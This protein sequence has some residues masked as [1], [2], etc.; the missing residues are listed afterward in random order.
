MS[1]NPVSSAILICLC[2]YSLSC[3]STGYSGKQEKLGQYF[4][5][6][7]T[8]PMNCGK[9]VFSNDND[10]FCIDLACER[11]EIWGRAEERWELKYSTS[12][13]E[14]Y[15]DCLKQL[16]KFSCNGTRV[17]IG[18][19]KHTLE[20]VECDEHK[21]WSKIGTIE[22]SDAMENDAYFSP[23][24]TSV[25]IISNSQIIL[26]SQGAFRVT[27][28][29]SVNNIW[30]KQG[31]IKHDKEVNRARFS[32]NGM[33][34][35]TASDDG[36]CKIWARVEGKWQ[37]TTIIIQHSQI[38]NSA[39]FSNDDNY[40]ITAS[41]DGCCKIFMRQDSQ[42]SNVAWIQNNIIAPGKA[43][44]SLNDDLAH[45]YQLALNNGS[46]IA[47][48]KARFNHDGTRIFTMSD[49]SCIR[50]WMCGDNNEWMRIAN[51]QSIVE[52]NNG[53]YISRSEK[54][55]VTYAGNDKVALIWEEN[56]EA[57]WVQKHS[58]ECNSKIKKIVFI[59]DG[60]HLMIMAEQTVI[61]STKE[62]K[63]WVN[64][65]IVKVD[66]NMTIIGSDCSPDGE[67]VVIITFNKLEL[68]KEED[69]TFTGVLTTSIFK[70]VSNGK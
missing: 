61:L 47:T 4:I 18:A 29:E 14:R 58:V 28:W 60:N 70:I 51:F 41:N 2:L 10:H 24:G 7:I 53:V 20:I 49:D 45:D 34:I 31:T 67:N 19:T 3:F 63:K 48:T 22:H 37:D 50:V 64:N 35:V 16:S 39:W 26:N 12:N 15:H 27:I 40:I 46:G 32:G 36:T 68:E 21:A 8:Y 54:R 9:A 44:L 33:Y 57:E 38:V 1:K 65:C 69:R 62:G 25:L 56:N 43:I 11:T 59:S 55:I 6:K 30:K 52:N 23:D 13:K 17:L 5:S 42:D 66:D